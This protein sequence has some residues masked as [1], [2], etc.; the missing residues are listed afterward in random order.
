MWS[1]LGKASTLNS[2]LLR[3]KIARALIL[4]ASFNPSKLPS[5]QPELTRAIGMLEDVL[6][7][8]QPNLAT[9]EAAVDLARLYVKAR[10]FDEAEKTLRFA[11]SFT[12]GQRAA[13]RMEVS[14]DLTGPFH[15]AARKALKRLPYQRDIGR[16][17]FEAARKL[18]HQAES[19]SGKR[20]RELYTRALKAYQ[21]VARGFPSTDYATRSRLDAG[22]CMVGLGRPDLALSH[23]KE[24]VSLEPAGPWRGQAYLA[25]I[26]LHLEMRLDLK[27]A[28]RY[29]ELARGSISTGLSGKGSS[30]SWKKAARDLWL[31]IGLIGYCLGNGDVA[32]GAFEKTKKLTRSRFKSDCLDVLIGAA[33]KG[34]AV[35]PEEAKGGKVGVA[36]QMGMVYTLAGDYDK[37]QVFFG[38]AGSKA[39]RKAQ[40]A[41]AVFGRGAVLGL[42][43]KDREAIKHLKNSLKDYPKG[44]WHDETLYRLATCIQSRAE[45]RAEALKYWERIVEGYPESPR[46]EIAAYNIAFL[47]CGLAEARA[48]EVSIARWKG[49]AGETGSFYEFWPESPYAG[50]L[51]VRRIDIALERVFD[52]ELA[53]DAAGEAVEWAEMITRK[54]NS[55]DKPLSAWHEV[56]RRPNLNALRPVIYECYQR[57]GLVAY[58]A[59]EKDRAVELFRKANGYDRSERK[60]AGVETSMRRMISL[61]SGAQEPLTPEELLKDIHNNKQ[62]T[63]LR[64]ADL[65]L[66][67]FEPERAG[68]LYRRLMTGERPF[69]RPSVKLHSYL[70][71]RMGQSLQFQG[72]HEEAMACLK[73]LYNSKY[74]KYPWVADGIFRMGTWAHN[75]TQDPKSGMKHWEYIFTKHPDHPEAERSLFYYGITALRAND[76]GK[77]SFAFREYLKRYPDSRW[78]NR[79]KTKLLPETQRLMKGNRE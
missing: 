56:V 1:A 69:P 44:T 36:L 42:L 29:A 13:D 58:L 57:A 23:W 59:G 14:G 12:Q 11:V 38:M 52:M 34:T 18:R 46:L 72:R 67:T 53:Q 39:N 30:D 75:T 31:R 17:E 77:A 78:T 20:Q 15:R 74:A 54:R 35:I 64:L 73:Q 19:A 28:A 71:L 65:A 22:H 10:R 32:A 79:I 37:A 9:A 47:R 5:E 24:F 50:E 21:K 66:M 40:S 33:E 51:C 76:Y 41:F 45:G 16:S 27:G 25:L 43:N 63:G 6:K 4:E 26:D 2:L 48:E 49:L 62:E 7:E 8:N 55:G 61:A 70:L 60:K 68:E 3:L